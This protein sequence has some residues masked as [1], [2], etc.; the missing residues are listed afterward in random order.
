[1]LIN[2]LIMKNIF[3]IYVLAL[4]VIVLTGCS[5]GP[6]KN[7]STEN[8]K[9]IPK[10]E[11]ATSANQIAPEVKIAEP[12]S[13]PQ[14]P[15]TTSTVQLT[16]QPSTV[17]FT[18]DKAIAA[19]NG[20]TVLD[21]EK[22]MYDFYKADKP[23]EEKLAGY[24]KEVD[25]LNSCATGT[26]KYLAPKTGL[27]PENYITETPIVS[28]GTDQESFDNNLSTAFTLKKYQDCLLS[29][30][31]SPQSAPAKFYYYN[32]LAK[33]LAGSFV[34]GAAFLL[35]LKD[36]SGG[37]AKVNDAEKRSF[38]K[39]FNEQGVIADLRD[40]YNM[41][42]VIPAIKKI[43]AEELTKDKTELKDSGFKESY[44]PTTTDEYITKKIISNQHQILSFREE[45]KTGDLKEFNDEVPGPIE[46]IEDVF[47][48]TYPE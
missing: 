6:V 39:N 34:E 44:I 7:I 28:S 18:L 3:K 23:T 4:A 47:Q 43:Y 1:M 9:E 33:S 25:F 2:W 24:F 46:T 48:K 31:D 21:L 26:Q 36:N 42:G 19:L 29:N 8:Q 38:C 15:I 27:S 20:K 40:Y 22:E 16:P 37:C 11:L 12:Q 45:D 32:S 30:L 41:S 5:I 10:T 13:T 35:N 14:P 17:T